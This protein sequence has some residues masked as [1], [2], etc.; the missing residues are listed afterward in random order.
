[1]RGSFAA[2]GALEMSRPSR[3]LETWGLLLE[4]LETFWAHLGWHNSLCIFKTKAS[5]GTTL[6]S[7]FYFYSVYNIL[8]SLC[9][10]GY[11]LN[12]IETNDKYLFRFLRQTQMVEQSSHTSCRPEFPRDMFAFRCCHGMATSV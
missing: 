2:E 9:L 5:R 8:L 4:S 11:L 6:C 10:P 3:S 12:N 1:M 7:Y